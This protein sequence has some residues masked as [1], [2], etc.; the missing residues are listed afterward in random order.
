MGTGRSVKK[1]SLTK[2]QG[3]KPKKVNCAVKHKGPDTDDEPW[4]PNERGTSAEELEGSP[5]SSRAG[6]CTE[7]L[8]ASSHRKWWRVPESSAQNVDKCSIPNPSMAVASVDP[9]YPTVLPYCMD[10]QHDPTE[11]VT[12]PCL[13]WIRDATSSVTGTDSDLCVGGGIWIP[14]WS[15]VCPFSCL[16]VGSL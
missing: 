1:N 7:V 14:V 9:G 15:L 3:S 6:G 10:L 16:V 5:R 11:T 8:T 12:D 2:S 4:V 13:T